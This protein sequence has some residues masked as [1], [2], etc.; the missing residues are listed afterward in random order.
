MIAITD[1]VL[2]EMVAAIVQA[3]DP[4]RIV[5]F[6]SRADGAQDIDSDI[7]LL[8]VERE[9]FGPERSRRRESLKIRRALSGFRIAKDIL[10]YSQDD[11]AE[12]RDSPN[13]VLTYALERGRCLYARP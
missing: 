5:L 1:E 11:V 2:D 10:V 6:G 3:S 9:P 4:E 12:W 7:D 8:I 13:H